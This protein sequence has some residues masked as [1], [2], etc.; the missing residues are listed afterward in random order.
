MH[1][2]F[3]DLEGVFVP[4]IW[5]NLAEKTGIEAFS[6]T[7]RDIPDYNELMNYRIDQMRKSSLTIHDIHDVVSRMKPLAGAKPFLDWLRSVTQIIVLS[8]TFV[9]FTAPLMVQLNFPTLLCHTLSTDAKGRITA[10]H[11]RTE[12]AKKAAVEAFRG[13]NYE[14][15]AM[16]DSYN[17]TAMLSVAHHGILFRPPENVAAEFPQFPVFQS[18]D[19]LRVI[20][21]K[22][23]G[24]SPTNKATGP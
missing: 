3:S 23:L 1:I 24:L 14:T 8:D 18:Y 4:E 11:I 10:Y 6:L 12:N 17:D 9:E 15:I 16:G 7:T 20:C 22:L 13:L 21:T 5:I 19:D 2:V